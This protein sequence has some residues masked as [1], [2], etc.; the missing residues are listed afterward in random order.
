M[1]EIALVDGES[2]LNE[3]FD[4][5]LDTASWD[6]DMIYGCLCQSESWTVGLNAGEYQVSEYFGPDCSLKRCPSGDDP[7][8]EANEMDCEDVNGGLAG[9]LCYVPC[10]NRGTCN[11]QT[12]QCSCYY[13]YDGE[14]CEFKVSYQ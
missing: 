8:T 10:A 13:G 14:N 3:Q 2:P 9:N 12:G 11:E 6:A 7:Q 5:G 1:A 4:Y